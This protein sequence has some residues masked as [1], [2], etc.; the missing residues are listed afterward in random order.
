M[1]TEKQRKIIIT[2]LEKNGLVSYACRK[3]GIARATYYRWIKENKKFSKI[4]KKALDNGT[5]EINDLGRGQL[6]LMMKNGSFSAIKYW[7][8]HR[9]LAFSEKNQF[10]KRL[11]RFK[12]DNQKTDKSKLSAKESVLLKEIIDRDFTQIIRIRVSTIKKSLTYSIA[13]QS[14]LQQRIYQQLTK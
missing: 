3:A 4:A 11:E 14:Q 2:E 1:K 6:I 13:N 5:L 9:D 12:I 8:S 10:I 7:L